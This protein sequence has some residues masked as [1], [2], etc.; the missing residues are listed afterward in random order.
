MKLKD[1][2]QAR[3]CPSVALYMNNFI[4][5]AALLPVGSVSRAAAPDK[6]HCFVHLPGSLATTEVPNVNQWGKSGLANSFGLWTS[7]IINH[8][9]SW[10]SWVW[11]PNRTVTHFL[12][13]NSLVSILTLLSLFYSRC[14]VFGERVFPWSWEE[15]GSGCVTSDFPSFTPTGTNGQCFAVLC[16]FVFYLPSCMQ[17]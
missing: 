15:K 17:Y 12:W 9:P 13:E 2:W 5:M 3:E 8:N 16:V 10:K 4:G 11:W 14:R 6:K 1:Y 7:F